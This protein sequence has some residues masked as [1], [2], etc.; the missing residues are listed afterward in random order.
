[1]QYLLLI[2]HLSTTRRKVSRCSGRDDIRKQGQHDIR[3]TC[4]GPYGLTENVLLL[5]SI[6]GS[7]CAGSTVMLTTGCEVGMVKAWEV[8]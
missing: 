8:F 1:M 3:R 2:C 4:A 6:S 5:R 7:T